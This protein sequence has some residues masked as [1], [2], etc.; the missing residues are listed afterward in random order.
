MRGMGRKYMRVIG[1]RNPPVTKRDKLG[2]RNGEC[3]AKRLS[4]AIRSI[5][6][7]I[8]SSSHR[9][10]VSSSISTKK[11]P[12][13]EI[14]SIPMRCRG[15]NWGDGQSL[16]RS[17]CRSGSYRGLLIKTCSSVQRHRYHRCHCHLYP[18]Q[19]SNNKHRVLRP[20]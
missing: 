20:S 1:R 10:T 5:Q 11:D 6:G 13:S 3:C 2:I 12:L 9:L 14:F 16:L 15:Q 17:L 4:I 18:H 7:L 19:R 8:V